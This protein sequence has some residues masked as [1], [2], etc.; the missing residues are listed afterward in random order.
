MNNRL[1]LPTQ[2]AAP[3][4]RSF[5]GNCAVA[6]GVPLL[7]SLP[8]NAFAASGGSSSLKVGLVGAGGRGKGAVQNCL[9]ADR[10]VSLW[11]IGEIFPDRLE[12]GRAA[13]AKRDSRANVPMDRCFSGFDA[14][15]RVLES[16]IDILIDATPPHFRP[17]HVE[18]AVAKG[19]H[20]FA[21]KPGAVDPEGCRRLIAAGEAAREKGLSIVAGTQRRHD[22]HY[23]ETMRRIADGAIGKLT[24]GQCYWVGGSTDSFWPHRQRRDDWTEM[25]YQI[26]NWYGFAWLCGDH[27]VEQH[28]HN[29][30]IM[31]WAFGGPPVK[32]FGMGGRQNRK[33][34]DIWD[35]FA[36]EFEYA[37]GARVA[38]Y[39]RQVNNT[40][41][42]VTER[43]VGE[44]GICRFPRT[45]TVGGEK[46]SPTGAAP[47][48]YVQE[49]RDLVAAIRSGTPVNEAR[50]LAEATLTGILGRTAA[51]TGAEINYA[52][53]RDT[54]KLSLSPENYDFKAAP[55]PSIE[56]VPGKTRPA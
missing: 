16:G 33:W 40:T 26:R 20:V 6:A 53:I 24:G 18:A 39:C 52:W 44:K 7:A 51:Y 2:A 50:A 3:S 17:I 28:V 47:N 45:I 4:R 12:S 25:E 10:N 14:Y 15:K 55:P 37:N 35:H 46:W 30:D 38:S 48:A 22:K 9:D 32:A 13:L 34:G 49:H 8:V 43:L 27:I 31:N 21:E 41:S 56:P 5:I 19:V 1:P 29:I 36:V 42:R 11:A 23:V 54:S